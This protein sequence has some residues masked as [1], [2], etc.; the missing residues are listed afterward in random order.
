M[1]GPD[2]A[3]GQNHL[4]PRAHPPQP[5]AVHVLHPNRLP[6]LKKDL[7]TRSI[8]KKRCERTRIPGF[9]CEYPDVM[10]C[11]PVSP[12]SM[13]TTNWEPEKEIRGILSGRPK[14]PLKLNKDSRKNKETKERRRSH[15]K[16][17]KISSLPA[18][19]SPVVL[20]FPV[21]ER[22]LVA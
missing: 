16:E 5:P 13:L 11:F 9:K 21:L 14:V 4:P 20:S 6:T 19:L 2:G 17:C 8:E 10:T 7:K 12:F 18:L 15:S 1:R 3:G 22:T